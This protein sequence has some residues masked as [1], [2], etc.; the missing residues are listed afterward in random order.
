MK[1][2]Q[3]V[4]P[5]ASGKSSIWRQLIKDH[6]ET[7]N[8][9]S[10]VVFIREPNDLE[11]I[12]MIKE[13]VDVFEK[14]KLYALDRQQLYKKFENDPPE[15]IVSDRSYI[16]SLVYQSLQV[17]LECDV[18]LYT[19]IEIVMNNQHQIRVPDLVIYTYAQPS[20]LYDRCVNRGEFM[21]PQYAQQL[22]RRYE[23]VFELFKLNVIKINTDEFDM[24]AIIKLVNEKIRGL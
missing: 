20:T 17:E 21:T 23:L 16:C 11:L 8:N 19:A 10:K 9:N 7:S 4:G 3:L 2:V 18:P 13:S 5:D 15:I 14:I 12:N 24:D 6:L 22:M 1:L